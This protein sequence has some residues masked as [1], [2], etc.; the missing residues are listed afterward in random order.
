MVEQVDF[1]GYLRKILLEYNDQKQHTFAN[2]E[3]S[4]FIREKANETIPDYLFPREKYKI[5]ASSGRGGWA[6][7]PWFAIFDKEITT[8]ALGGYYIVYLF[9]SDGSGIYATLNQGYTKIKDLYKSKKA[10]EN[11]KMLSSYWH[12]KLKFLTVANNSVFSVDEINL[13]SK[14]S[15]GLPEGYELGNICSK[16]YSRDEFLKLS[17]ND[18]LGDLV[19]LRMIFSELR[20][21]I[22]TSDYEEFNEE[23]LK[24]YNYIADENEEDGHVIVEKLGGEVTV[25]K[26]LILS[27]KIKSPIGK[28]N[29]MD[30]LQRNTKQGIIAEELVVIYEKERIGK[31]KHLKDHVSSIRHVSKEEGDGHGYDI[32]SVYFDEISQ[33]VKPFYIEVKSTIK[34]I[35]TPF[36]LSEN[37]LRVAEKEGKNYSIYRLF[38]G[39]QGKF[40]YYIINDPFNNIEYKP[41]QYKVI[42]KSNQ[43]PF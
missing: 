38:R 3:L 14:Q 20:N 13:H 15:G 22:G 11:I 29:Y 34:G 33:E 28:K 5:S 18:L 27:D 32:E 25:P 4:K 36:Y 2:N 19:Q 43:Y 6:E 42:P 23:I 35:G 10:K 24:N 26:N 41:I 17:N 1:Y 30:E 40:D 7:I 37:E 12:K 16:F 21:F 39:S 8:S 9:R 31:D